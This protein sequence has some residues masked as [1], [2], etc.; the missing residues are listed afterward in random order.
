MRNVFHITNKQKILQ[1]KKMRICC[2]YAVKAPTGLSWPGILQNYQKRIEEISGWLKNE[3]TDS[4]VTF[5]NKTVSAG[6][7]DEELLE[8]TQFDGVLVFLLAH[9][10]GIG[11]RLVS[12]MRHGLII[13]DPFGGSGDLIRISGIIHN[14][15]YPV[16]TVGTQDMEALLHKIRVY[17]AVPR[18]AGSRILVFKNFEKMTPVKEAEMVRSIGTGSTMKR[19][20]AG[21]AGFDETVR[22]IKDTFSIDVVMKDL[23]A[24]K[25][26]M[27]GVDEEEAK[28]YAKKWTENAEKVVEPS[29][30][31]ILAAA[32]MYLALTEAKKETHADVVSIDCILMFFAY[33]MGVYPCLSFFEMN[34]NGE[35][36]I[37]EGD[38]DSAISSLI[39]QKISGRPGFVS[40]PFVDTE[41]NQITYA[42]C[43]ASAKP[44]GPQTSPYPYRIRTHSEDESSAAVQ[45][46]LPAGYP[47]TTIKI[48]AA[49]KAMSIHSGESI[50]NI[51]TASGCRTKL[52][53]KIPSSRILLNNWHNELFSWH[54]VTV[55]GDY[56][57]DFMDIAQ[58]FNLKVYE[59]DKENC[60]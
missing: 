56:R 26:Y 59:E 21:K 41:K 45:V 54:R 51:D 7:S 52:V 30:S 29:S 32:K 19:Y 57:N 16:Q 48:S 46:M 40:D 28:Q 39:I 12:K 53:A 35:I 2:A 31:D 17:L 47:V 49:N 23:K 10:T 9:G 44:F 42:H 58:Y 22:Q 60:N 13:D 55:F 15:K 14:E 36:G 6:T 27:S 34:N 43:V 1:E 33:D 18:I 25:Q 37:C 4:D 20:R 8:I 50:G 24:L 3:I 11:Q 5:V 38:L